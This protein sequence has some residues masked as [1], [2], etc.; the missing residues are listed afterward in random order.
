[1]HGTY[2][3]LFRKLIY[4]DITKRTKVISEGEQLTEMTREKYSFLTFPPTVT[5]Q[6]GV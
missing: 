1:M 4:I 3:I 5:V 2:Y 6:H